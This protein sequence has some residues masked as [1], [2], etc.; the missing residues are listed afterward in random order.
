MKRKTLSTFTI[1][2]LL[3]I[4]ISTQFSCN[5]TDELII[6]P[7]LE[8][9]LPLLEIK[10][11]QYYVLKYKIR[12]VELVF[13][14]I[15]EEE[16]V[17]GNIEL[18]DE[19]ESLASNYDLIVEGKVIFIRFHNDFFLNDGWKYELKLSTGL[20]SV[21]GLTFNTEEIIEFRTTAKHISEE[22][23]GN[24]NDTL[25]RT[26]IACISDI[27]CGDERATNGNYSWFGKNA[28]ALEDFLNFIKNNQEVKELVILGDLFDEWMVPYEFSPFD[29]TINITNSKEYFHAIANSSTNKPVFDKMQEIISEG[30]ID[31]IYVPGNHDMLITQEILAEIIPGA[32]WKS[33]ATGLGKYNPVDEILMEHG[34]RYDFFNCPQPLVND[35]HILPP[36]YFVSRLYAAGL[37]ARKPQTI[38]EAVSTSS[39]AEFITA[40]TVAFGYTIGTFMMDVDTIPMDSNIVVMNGIDGYSSSL[41]FDGA[42]DMYAANIEELWYD[43]QQINNVPIPMSVFL[44]IVNGTYL[45]GGAVY[46]Y[47]IDFLSP[48]A[49]KIVAFGHSHQPELKVFPFEHYYTGIYANSGSWL[50]DDQSKYK[51]RTFLV[52]NPAEWSGSNL[53]V[54][55]L[56]QY[57]PDNDSTGNKYKPVLLDE[58][59]IHAN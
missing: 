52:V 27:H 57:N 43:T 42:R 45:Y 13:S 28:A 35:G 37:A 11:D 40:W 2:L 7:V 29:S 34:H 9:S 26:L 12:S 46:E 58:E 56:Y 59:S 15:I 44:A 19:Y 14:N 20:S 10:Y 18:F 21:E 25:E 33:D 48:D 41:S 50:D 55:S 17:T 6:K 31:I 54:V 24:I 49:P 39:D 53:D 4:T 22:M 38:K 16:T 8:I 47:L 23:V 30:E 3:S 51:V 5:R 32:Q 36:G 1:T